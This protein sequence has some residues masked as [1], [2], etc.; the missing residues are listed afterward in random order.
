MKNIGISPKKPYWPKS[1]KY[2]VKN[3]VCFTLWKRFYLTDTNLKQ[4]VKSE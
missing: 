3:S 1:N 2:S 4:E